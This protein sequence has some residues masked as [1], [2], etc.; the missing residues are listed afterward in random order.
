MRITL[1]STYSGLVHYR[2]AN[3][4]RLYV[5]HQPGPKAW[6][7][8]LYPQFANCAYGTLTRLCFYTRK[9]ANLSP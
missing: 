8:L 1:D 4:Y 6:V 5:C 9:L 3:P 7:G 2:T